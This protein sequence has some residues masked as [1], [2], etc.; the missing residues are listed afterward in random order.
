MSNCAGFLLLLTLAGASAASLTV[1]AHYPWSETSPLVHCNARIALGAGIS[2]YGDHREPG[3]NGTSFPYPKPGPMT[4]QPSKTEW[5]SSIDYRPQ[6][7][8]RRVQLTFEIIWEMASNQSAACAEVCP[9]LQSSPFLRNLGATVWVELKEGGTQADAWPYFCTHRGKVA[10][11][12]LYSPEL[13][14]NLTLSVYRPPGLVENPL[15][16]PSAMAAFHDGFTNIGSSSLVSTILD[17]M[18]LT[19]E[20]QELVVVGIDSKN[21][22]SF[23]DAIFTPYKRN[24]SCVCPEQSA[25]C[26]PRT[27]VDPSGQGDDYL[28]FLVKQ[29]L[30]TMSA[31]L[32]VTL[33]RRTTI[34][35][36]YS[37][38]GLAAAY[39]A[40]AAPETFGIV[41]TGSPSLW[42]NCGEIVEPLI[43]GVPPSSKLY[44]DWGNAVGPLEGPL[45]RMVYQGLLQR[46]GFSDGSNVWLTEVEG[47]YHE[48]NGFFKRV[49]RALKAVLPPQSRDPSHY[50][51]PSMDWGPTYRN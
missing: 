37:K 17:G 27:T 15:P 48:P 19:G 5:T 21:G 45:Q 13:A 39:H 14:T 46:D 29:V 23:R 18:I 3:P 41:I 30:P 25:W 36:G 24:N 33:D 26:I 42:Y 28:R 12:T 49:P 1:T 6:D 9:T 2:N 31:Q 35:W 16:R 10:D 22:T 7:V 50:E 4:Q 38:G 20:I 11:Q 43:A 44:M 34:S 47:D 51:P 32:G 40:Y 8:G